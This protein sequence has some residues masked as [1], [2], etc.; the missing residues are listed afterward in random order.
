M[1]H[2][3]RKLNT[4]PSTELGFTGDSTQWFDE[5]AYR[6]PKSKASFDEA[7]KHD[8][9]FNSYSSHHI[10]EEMLK[11][12]HR[13]NT[14]R[15]AIEGNKNQFKDKIVLDIGCGTGIL[16]I[17]AARAGAKHV[18]AIDAAEIAHFARE[19]VKDNKLTDKITVLHGKIEE[20]DLPF[21]EGEVDIIISEWMGYFLLYES[22]LDCVL[23]AR[24][25]FLNKET[26]KM[27]PDRAKLYV[28]AIED[29]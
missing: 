19:I 6:F 4:V 9:Y 23:W 7:G 16:S 3:N 25:K 18:Y 26:G 10:H 20:L 2:V 17:F 21:K 1:V 28:S 11:D 29:S 5:E 13:T 27:L 14:Y 22:M 15:E 24:D 8:Y 12:A